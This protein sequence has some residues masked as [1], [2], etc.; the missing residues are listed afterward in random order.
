M[1]TLWMYISS[2]ISKNFFFKKSLYSIK[3]V[4]TKMGRRKYNILPFV[5]VK[6]LKMYYDLQLVL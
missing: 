1:K 3:Y 4:Y 2:Q 5:A 6:K